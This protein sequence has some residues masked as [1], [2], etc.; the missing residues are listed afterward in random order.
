MS[1]PQLEAVTS[2]SP[3]FWMKEW[4]M[5]NPEN[6]E[7]SICWATNGIPRQSGRRVFAVGPFEELP[8]DKASFGA[9][10]Y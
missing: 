3:L 9:V 7:E 4:R 8:S 10:V 2:K 5:N 1:Q 6:L